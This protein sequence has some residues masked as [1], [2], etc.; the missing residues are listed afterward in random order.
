M[1]RLINHMI[2]QTLPC[3]FMLTL[4]CRIYSKFRV[5]NYPA[6]KTF[7]SIVAPTA[8]PASSPIYK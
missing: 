8:I 4:M 2:R 1:M 5:R 7:S 3:T 6:M